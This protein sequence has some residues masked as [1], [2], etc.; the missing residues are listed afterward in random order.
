VQEVD[1][2]RVREQLPGPRLEPLTV[3]IVVHGVVDVDDGEDVV[4]QCV[5]M[6]Q[7]DSKGCRKLPFEPCRIGGGTDVG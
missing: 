5:R 3:Q 1:D 4:Q 2:S 7:R 6:L